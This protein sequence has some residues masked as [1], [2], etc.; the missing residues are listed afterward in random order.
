M[1]LLLMVQAKHRVNLPHLIPS[2]L[3]AFEHKMIC[4]RPLRVWSSMYS[5]TNKH[6]A[7]SSSTSNIAA[8]NLRPSNEGA[9]VGNENMGFQQIGYN[10]MHIKRV[11]EAVPD[12]GV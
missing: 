12:H 11:T 3:F 8:A 10:E 9:A 1:V 2:F 4:L 7:T 6:V 5:L